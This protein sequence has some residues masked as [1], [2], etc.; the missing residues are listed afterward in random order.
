[1]IKQLIKDLAYDSIT[2]SQGLTRAKLIE[3]QVKNETFKNWLKKELEGYDFEDIYL[4]PYRKVWSNIKLTAE[5]PFG[6]TQSF[7]VTLPDTFDEKIIDTVNHHRILEPISIVEQQI[8]NVDGVKGYI[9]LPAQMIEMLSELYVDQVSKYRGVIRSGSREIGKVQYQNVLEQ[10]KQKLLDTLLQLD[11]E[12]P[13]L[14]DTYT[15][16]EENNKKVE[17]IITNNI[18]GN[19]NPLNIAAGENVQQTNTTNINQQ[20][21]AKL[22]GLGVN[23]QE[24][25]ELQ[26]I[27][28][29]SKSDKKTFGNKVMSWLGKVSVSIAGRGLYDNIPQ[30]TEFVQNLI[31]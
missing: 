5:F 21:I 11:G 3:N 23:E 2:L 28:A 18:Y 31:I 29:D 13:N 8:N 30:L 14:S 20:D 16:N 4:P 7:P 9:N 19:N 10:T 6:Q 22:G 26:Q 24:I 17:N 27:I 25:S 12:F 1:M 15:M